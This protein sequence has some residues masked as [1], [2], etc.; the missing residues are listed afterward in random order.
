[1]T[2]Q[3]SNRKAIGR[4]WIFWIPITTLR[5]KSCNIPPKKHTCPLIFIH[6]K[7]KFALLSWSCIRPK[8]IDI[9]LNPY[10]TKEYSCLKWINFA[11]R[12]EKFSRQESHCVVFLNNTAI[13]R[14]HEVDCRYLS[15]SPGCGTSLWYGF[16]LT[17][18]NKAH[19]NSGKYGK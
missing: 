8:Y 1:M 19:W 7:T 10:L 11:N 2:F 5:S 3:E 18:L 4:I 14:F 17:L 9:T 12:Y 6:H 15:C 13:L 16:A